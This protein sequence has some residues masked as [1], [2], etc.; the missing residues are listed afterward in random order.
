MNPPRILDEAADELARAAAYLEGERPGCAQ[1]FLGAYEETLNQLVQFPE[2]GPAV[3]GLS[4]RCQLRSFLIHRFRYSV[5]V[6]IFDGTPTIVAVAHASRKPGYW[7]ERIE[8][9]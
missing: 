6:G 9:A 7:L 1:A 8:P 5:I 3:A 4:N 2:S